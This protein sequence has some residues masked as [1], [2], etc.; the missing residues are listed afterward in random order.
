MEILQDNPLL[1]IDRVVSVV[2]VLVASA[3]FEDLSHQSLVGEEGEV[4]AGPLQ[5]FVQVSELRL[6]FW[7]KA[8]VLRCV[9]VAVSPSAA[10]REPLD[11]HGQWEILGLFLPLLLSLGLP[12]RRGSPRG[13]LEGF[14]VQ[15]GEI[16]PQRSDLILEALKLCGERRHSFPVTLLVRTP[17]VDFDPEDSL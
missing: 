8:R 10:T 12:H 3:G 2:F 4:W 11:A 1:S 16:Y 5:D 14:W 9:L 13:V 7:V 6:L 17:A 15:K